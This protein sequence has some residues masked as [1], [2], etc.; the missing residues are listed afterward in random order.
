MKD[1]RQASTWLSAER[2]CRWYGSSCECYQ[3]IKDIIYQISEPENTAKAKDSYY[4][5]TTEKKMKF[6]VL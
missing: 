5:D 4:E 3:N 2:K 6:Q 1:K